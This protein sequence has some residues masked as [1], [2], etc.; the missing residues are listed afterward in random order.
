M[1]ACSSA[2]RRA[3]DVFLAEAMAA[4]RMAIHSLASCRWGPRGGGGESVGRVVWG[5]TIAGWHGG[6]AR[7]VVW[8]R[9]DATMLGLGGGAETQVGVYLGT[10]GN[11]A[12]NTVW[13]VDEE[14]LALIVLYHDVRGDVDI[15]KRV[16]R[17]GRLPFVI[18]VVAGNNRL[19]PMVRRH[20]NNAT[21]AGVGANMA[22]G[23]KC[24]YSMA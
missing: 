16:L 5:G 23:H 3:A 6:V 22:F 7:K 18:P 12:V 8:W 17:Q 19:A 14:A 4:R 20:D 9:S 10:I 21:T 15:P 13:R 11:G 2:A 1:S 24:E